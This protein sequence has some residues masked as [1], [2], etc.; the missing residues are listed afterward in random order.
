[1]HN[2]TDLNDQTGLE[3]AAKLIPTNRLARLDIDFENAGIGGTWVVP[4]ELDSATASPGAYIVCLRLA[5]GHT[6]SIP[7]LPESRLH[8]GWYA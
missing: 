3:E 1:M 6:I 4:D 5:L 7:R 8:A 2:T